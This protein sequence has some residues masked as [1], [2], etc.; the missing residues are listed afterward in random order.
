MVKLEGFVSLKSGA[1]G[2]FCEPQGWCSWK[3]L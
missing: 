2:R 1:V 3:V